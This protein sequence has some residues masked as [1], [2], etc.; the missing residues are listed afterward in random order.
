MTEQT[1]GAVREIDEIAE[2]I[3]GANHFLGI[4][5]N[6][7]THW[8]HLRNAVNDVQDMAE[9]LYEK[10]DFEEHNKTLLIDAEA[11]SSRIVNTLHKLTGAMILG[12][13]DSLLIYF[14]GHGFLDENKEGYWAP[15]E[16]EIGRAHV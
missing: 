4:G 3:K 1:K 10:Y 2:K 16:S 5:I 6:D 7:Y 11:T 14:S 13:H 12:E 9:V 15:F 8:Q